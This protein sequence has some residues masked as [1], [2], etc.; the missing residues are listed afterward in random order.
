MF[1]SF[2]PSRQRALTFLGFVLLFCLSLGG[3][4]AYSAWAYADRNLFLPFALAA[5]IAGVI[6]VAAALLFIRL[7]GTRYDVLEGGLILRLGGK[8]ILLPHHR[9]DWLRPLSDFKD[10]L[11][12]PSLRLPGYIFGKMPIKGLGTT[13]F[14]A[15][16]KSDF[17]LLSSAGQAY[18]ISPHP[19]AE[20]L[21]AYRSN[22]ERYP[23]HDLYDPLTTDREIWRTIFQQPLSRAAIL[24]GLVLSFL[25][26]GFAAFLVSTREQISWVDLA[27]VPSTQIY[28]LPILATLIWAFNLLVGFL[29]Y[30]EPNMPK[31]AAQWLWVAGALMP[32]IVGAAM[33]LL[34]L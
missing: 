4:F 19:K 13:F 14:A 29:I 7:L 23:L 21:S 1:R 28:L 11:P 9:I 22:A 34:S 25:L 6:A 3:F 2:W 5:A 30:R 18:L 26:W 10:D 24:A 15:T 27:F 17:V 33:L 31:L 8:P 16:E 20:F 12:M 32:L